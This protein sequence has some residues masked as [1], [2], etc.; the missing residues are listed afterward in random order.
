M[1]NMAI[2]ERAPRS[3]QSILIFVFLL[4]FVGLTLWLFGQRRWWIPPVASAHGVAI[5]NVF[6]IIL[7]I[8]GV[9]FVMLQLTVAVCVLCFGSHRNST[10][11]YRINRKLEY[12][13]ALIAGIIIFCI[14][15]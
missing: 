4:L 12:R 3:V 6:A 2:Q 11:R 9:L 13:F 15:V 1:S 10:S 5:D 7:T 14:D 8:A